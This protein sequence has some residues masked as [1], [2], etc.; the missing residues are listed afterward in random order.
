MLFRGG[1][2][3]W[4]RCKCESS[5]GHRVYP[6]VTTTVRDTMYHAPG[7]TDTVLTSTDWTIT[8]SD[9]PHSRVRRGIRIRAIKMEKYTRILQ[10]MSSMNIL[11]V[12]IHLSMT[13]SYHAVTRLY[14][15]NLS[16]LRRLSQT[17]KSPNST[18]TMSLWSRLSQP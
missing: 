2:I 18:W 11:L 16:V 8:S 12:F 1:D 6:R 4:C 3:L 17:I 5:Q 9:L 7:N 13:D 14:P 15:H 10:V